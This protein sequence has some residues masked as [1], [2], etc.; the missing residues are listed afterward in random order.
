MGLYS[1]LNTGV[2]GLNVNS[3]SM[4]V[5]GD[6]IANVNTVGFKSGVTSFQDMLSQNTLG[7]GGN[8]IVGSGATVNAINLN[9]AQGSIG[10]SSNVT[11]MAIGG[12]GFFVVQSP[13]SGENLFTRNGQFFIDTSG[14]LITGDGYTLQ[15]FRA[16]AAGK[17]DTTVQNLQLNLGAQPPKSTTSISLDASLDSGAD[18]GGPAVIDTAGTDFTA[19]DLKE[20]ATFSTSTVIYDSLGETH[21]ASIFFEKTGENQWTWLAVAST[22]ELSSGA[23]ADA[24]AM[25]KVASGV[26]VFKTDGTIDSELSPTDTPAPEI[27]FMGAEVQSVAMDF[28]EEGNVI[29]V[30]GASTVIGISQD[31]FGA[32]YLSNLSVDENGVIVGKYSNGK[33]NIIGQIALAT[34]QSPSGVGLERIGGSLFRATSDAGTAAIGAA[35]SGGRGKINAYS[36]ELSNVD[37]ETEFSRMITSQLGYQANSKVISTT[38]DMLQRLIQIV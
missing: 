30:A 5:V 6:N 10:K 2:S 12:A 11:D 8:V 22:A 35:N 37:L 27:T 19:S 4:G 21:D 14:T 32:G 9:F 28:S 31:G 34:F 36:M 38:N 18:I 24:D 33:E 23:G 16:D 1:T 7:S 29:Q 15:G 13:T 17:L 20:K 26:L 25:T 3:T